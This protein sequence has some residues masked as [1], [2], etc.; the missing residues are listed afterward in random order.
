MK[1]KIFFI[2]LS[3]IS[4]LVLL[5]SCQKDLLDKKPL[6]KISSADVWI[7]K[8]LADAYMIDLYA[9][10]CGTSYLTWNKPHQ[11]DLWSDDIQTDN[12]NRSNVV[13]ETLTVSTDVGFDKYP[14]IRRVNVA[15]DNLKS[16]ACVI[17]EPFKS[18]LLAEAKCFRAIIYQ[19]LVRRF[20]GVM[21]VD[22]VFQPEDEMMIPR[23][24]ETE[25]YNFI[26]ED[27]T[28][29]KN[30]LPRTVVKGKLNR[31]SAHGFLIRALLD[32]RRYDDV[33]R[34]CNEFLVTENKY[35]YSIDPDYNGIFNLYTSGIASP[36]PIFIRYGDE[37]GITMTN[38]PLQYILPLSNR[39][40]TKPTT[41]WSYIKT[42]MY[43]WAMY[44]PT[45]QHVDAYEV[46]ENGV[47][48]NWWETDA[49]INRVPGPNSTEVMWKNRDKRFYTNI[50]YDGCTYA[51][52]LYKMRAP[53]F[54][55]RR[56]MATN[57]HYALTG[58][59]IRK[60]ASDYMINWT[61]TSQP[62][63]FHWVILRLGEIYL[64][65]SEALIRKGREAEAL[66][67]I[68]EL[69]TKHGKMPAIIGTAGLLDKYK[70][71]RRVEMFMEK[72]RYWSLIRWGKEENLAVI[73]ELNENSRYIDINPDGSQFY[74]STIQGSLYTARGTAYSGGTTY[75]NSLIP[76]DRTMETGTTHPNRV[77]TTKRYLLPIPKSQL[78][79]N[80]NLTQNPGWN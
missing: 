8:G 44:F 29:A 5:T 54:P 28:Y 21:K 3:M 13:E 24:T 31:A 77:F 71:E 47:A 56:Q 11:D 74:I 55:Y 42:S 51:G 72:D 66:P 17:K 58:Y 38:T 68:N 60:T 6:D 30:N 25:I 4:M 15:I 19:F 70:R 53:Y 18:Q 7:D 35:G 23:A 39:E 41:D 80:A 73:P 26:I 61:S 75:F 52:D 78:D 12:G 16:P 76:T 1:K 67:W 69:R 36:E 57:Q 33:I 9:R 34:E 46:V 48:K 65:Y 27:L 62:W 63:P 40:R 22:R 37:S 43:G 59:L 45:Q 32:A 64:D 14:D 49:W 2:S 50:T 10:V 79:K 20:G